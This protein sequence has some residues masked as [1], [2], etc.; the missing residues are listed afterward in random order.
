MATA[1]S[2]PAAVV[3]LSISCAGWE[4]HSKTRLPAQTCY[5]PAALHVKTVAILTEQDEGKIAVLV[6]TITD[7]KRLYEL[8][9]LRVV[10]LRFTETAR[11]RILKVSRQ[12]RMCR[13]CVAVQG[14]TMVLYCECA[15]HPHVGRQCC[16]HPP[17]YPPPTRLPSQRRQT[18]AHSTDGLLAVPCSRA[19][20]A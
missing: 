1:S 17:G 5:S 6:G 10:A 20:S 15:P 14:H 11:A 12:H 2:L 18:R 8:P 16:A 7:D 19:A 9:K 4:L 13:E 3:T